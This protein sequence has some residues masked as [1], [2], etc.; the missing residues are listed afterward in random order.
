[1]RRVI[2]E[3]AGIL[4]RSVNKN[5]E[6]RTDFRAPPEKVMGDPG[7]L[8]QAFL[9]L[10]VNAGD[11]MP[12]GGILTFSTAPFLSD[13]SVYASDVLVPEGRYLSASVA[14]TGCGIPEAI[15]DQVFAPFFTTKA[16]GEGTG[17]GLSMVYSCVRSHGGFVGLESREGE[18]TV[19]RILLPIAEETVEPSASCEPERV[20]R[21]GETILVID[22][23]DI[24]L[25][26]LCDMLRSLGY[27][28]LPATSGEEGIEMLASAPDKMDLVILDKI[29]PGMD[30]AG[31][32]R[33]LRE[34]RQ[35]LPVI[36]CSGHAAEGAPEARA[37]GDFDDF[38]QKPY[39]RDTLA[40]KV[41]AVLDGKA[42]RI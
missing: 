23:D 5:V 26:L 2:E 35:H 38:L 31:T 21:G 22:D 30:G 34:I 18:G 42:S 12:E 39:E 6:I 10:G 33:R 24:P 25:R 36:L 17:L 8:V 4:S 1:L 29:M 41:R 14:D 19:F 3:A 40:R 7:A 32:L 20:P 27:T 9:N 28:P 13:G 16:P 11:A 15:R 37:P